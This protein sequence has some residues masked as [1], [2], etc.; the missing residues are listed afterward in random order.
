M[1]TLIDNYD[2]FTYN[3]VHFLGELGASTQV[4]RNDKI[5][6][7]EVLAEAPEAIVL[8]PGPCDPD[9]AGICLELIER[10]GPVVPILGVC[11]GHQAIGQVYGDKVVRALFDAQPAVEVHHTGKEACSL[12]C[13]KTSPPPVIIRSWSSATACPKISRSLR[14]LPT[15]SSW[16][17]ST[18]AIPCMAY[19]LHPES[20]ASNGHQLLANFL[21]LAR[22]ERRARGE[23]AKKKAVSALRSRP[24]GRPSPKLETAIQ[25]VAA[26]ESLS[27]LEA[28][29]A[30]DVIMSGG[31][32]DAR[33]SVRF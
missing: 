3:L 23:L 18:S 4:Y 33:R 20:I 8:S 5:T 14:R 29:Q 13:R 30:F 21:D 19:G 24:Y 32:T 9:R 10:A 31:A 12:A 22:V 7:D 6:V 25:K 2:S 1:L 15:A 26:G 17:C 27:Q 11:L 16:A 28:A